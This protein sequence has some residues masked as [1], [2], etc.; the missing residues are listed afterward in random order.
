MLYWSLSNKVA[1]CN[2]NF[3][4]LAWKLS[5]KQRIQSFMEF[6]SYWSTSKIKVNI[7]SIEFHIKFAADKTVFNRKSFKNVKGKV[8]RKVPIIIA[9]R[10]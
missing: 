9:N 4:L 2:Y 3:I 1:L 10:K 5:I 8:P 7:L 6:N